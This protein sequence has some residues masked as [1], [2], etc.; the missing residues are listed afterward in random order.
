MGRETLEGELDLP[1]T[2][3]SGVLLG[4]EGRLASELTVKTVETFL[5]GKPGSFLELLPSVPEFHR[6]VGISQ[7]EEVALDGVAVDLQG[8]NQF[9][10]MGIF[11][12]HAV[13]VQVLYLGWPGTSG[14]DFYDYVLA[15]RVVLP[16]ENFQHFS[17]KP[18]WLPHCYQ[19]NDRHRQAADEAPSRGECHLPETGFVFCCFN[20]SFKILP[21]IFDV[22]M[23]L[24]HAVPGSVLWL[25]ETSERGMDNLIREAGARGIDPKRLVFAPRLSNPLHLARHA[26][27]DLVLDT[28][29]YNA[30]TTASDALWCG[31]PV[32]TC[33][34]RT[35]ASRV[36]TSLLHN[37]GLAEL[38]T[39]NLAD[40]EALALRLAADPSKLAAMK[41]HLRAQRQAAPLFDSSR[42]AGDIEKAYRE[43]IRRADA[44]L[45]PAFL[46]VAALGD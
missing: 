21:E 15:D 44:G 11:S 12:H 20:N 3:Q 23:R 13:P 6:F 8:F 18:V 42:L 31:V 32:L 38:A 16:E 26:H 33:T 7:L 4:G 22:W 29:P 30:H 19:P 34:G 45:A 2:D 17:E 25:L 5:E 10:R 39:A 43:M 37:V 9:N 1:E 24:L 28:L 46:D 35:F 41:Q 14:A 36:A 40:Y 27:A